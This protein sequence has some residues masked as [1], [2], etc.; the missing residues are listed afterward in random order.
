MKLTK[1]KISKIIK[2][3]NQS[4]KKFNKKR[5]L[6]PFSVKNK[7]KNNNLNKKSLKLQ[8]YK[9]TNSNK[10]KKKKKVKKK[11]GGAPGYDDGYS[12]NPYATE[13]FTPISYDDEDIDMGAAEFGG[14]Y[15]YNSDEEREAQEN[16]SRIHARAAEAE[17]EEAER[18]E[19][20][21][22]LAERQKA[23]RLKA[24]RQKAER[25]LAE[26]QLAQQQ[27]AQ[28]Q[29]TQQQLAQPMVTKKEAERQ[30]AREQAQRQQ[31]ERLRQREEQRAQAQR[32]KAER[33]RQKEEQRA[34]TL[35]QRAE[36]KEA[37]R[38]A[39]QP[40]KE[41]QKKEREAERAERQKYIEQQQRDITQQIANAERVRKKF[42]QLNAQRKQESERL[43]Q[44]RLT[45]QPE[46]RLS[47]SP[48][49]GLDPT[50]FSQPPASPTPV[51]ESSITTPISSPVTTPVSSPLQPKFISTTR[52]AF[53]LP[54]E[55]PPSRLDAHLD[56]SDRPLVLNP[57]KTGDGNNGTRKTSL[58][59]SAKSAIGQVGTRAIA[60]FRRFTQ[61]KPRAE[62]PKHIEM[63]TSKRNVPPS[64][65]PQDSLPD[66]H[67]QFQPEIAQFQ[68]EI[69]SGRLSS[70]NLSSRPS[71]ISLKS[72]LSGL[73]SPELSH[74]SSISE[75]SCGAVPDRTETPIRYDPL[76]S[77]RSFRDLVPGEGSRPDQNQ[78]LEL[79]D[80]A[81]TSPPQVTSTVPFE[82]VQPEPGRRSPPVSESLELQDTSLPRTRCGAVANLGS[83]SQPPTPPP[84]QLS[85]LDEAPSSRIIPGSIE[86][87]TIRGPAPET[88]EEP[89]SAR[90]NT[91]FLELLDIINDEVPD[92]NSE[93]LQG[94]IN[95]AFREGVDKMTDGDQLLKN[96]EKKLS[97][98]K[99]DE[100]KAR[101]QQE[102]EEKKVRKEGEKARKQQEK[103][104]KKL[105]KEWEKE[106]K[107]REKRN[108]IQNKLH[109][110]E[111]EIM[112]G[113]ETDSVK[114]LGKEKELQENLESFAIIL[115]NSILNK[116][117]NNNQN[118][119]INLEDKVSKTF[120]YKKLIKDL[121]DGKVDKEIK[122]FDYNVLNRIF[123]A[124]NI[125]KNSLTYNFLVK[126]NDI[127]PWNKQ[128]DKEDSKE[129]INISGG[130]KPIVKPP[131]TK[132]NPN[133][134]IDT[135]SYLSPEN[136]SQTDEIS[137]LLK[138]TINKDFP[139]LNLAY[140]SE[141]EYKEEK[142]ESLQIKLK[143]LGSILNKSEVDLLKII[144]NF[145]EKMLEINLDDLKE[146]S[147]K[148]NKIVNTLQKLFD[149][150]TYTYLGIKKGVD[151]QKFQDARDI[152]M[153]K[154]DKNQ[155]DGKV[156]GRERAINS[157]KLRKEE[158]EKR[159]ISLEK[160]RLENEKKEQE[161]ED[162]GSEYGIKGGGVEDSDY[163][164]IPYK[165]DIN[166]GELILINTNNNLNSNIIFG[167]FVD[168]DL[169]SGV[170]LFLDKPLAIN[171]DNIGEI[172]IKLEYTPKFNEKLMDLCKQYFKDIILRI[173]LAT[174]INNPCNPR[175]ND[176][177]INRFLSK[178]MS[179]YADTIQP[180]E[181]K[182]FKFGPDP[183]KEKIDQIILDI[184]KFIKSFYNQ[185]TD[186]NPEEKTPEQ[187]IKKLEEIKN[188]DF[189][190]QR[191][192]FEELDEKLQSKM[193]SITEA[194]DGEN[195]DIFTDYYKLCNQDVVNELR[196]KSQEDEKIKD[197]RLSDKK[198][199]YI[200][201][202]FNLNSFEELFF[203]KN[204]NEIGIYRDDR[205]DR[206][207]R[208]IFKL[209]L[210]IYEINQEPL[211]IIIEI[212]NGKKTKQ[213]EDREDQDRHEK[214]LQQIEE[215]SR[216]RK[217][218]LS[219][220]EYLQNIREIQPG[221]FLPGE[222]IYNP[223][224]SVGNSAVSSLTTLLSKNKP[225]FIPSE[226]KFEAPGTCAALSGPSCGALTS[227]DVSPKPTNFGSLA[228]GTLPLPDEDEALTNPQLNEEEFKE[229]IKNF[230]TD[231]FQNNPKIIE[232]F[233]KDHS[234]VDSV[235]I[236]ENIL[237]RLNNILDN[238][239]EEEASE[240]GEEES[241]APPEVAQEEA[242]E[243]APEA[244][245][246]VS[247][248][249]EE[250]AEVDPE[251]PAEVEAEQPAEVEEAPAVEEPP[252]V[253]E[254]PAAETPVR[255]A[256]VEGEEL[257]GGG[258]VF[259]KL[260][261]NKEL[262]IKNNNAV[263]LSNNKFKGGAKE[264]DLIVSQIYT[265]I[266]KFFEDIKAIQPNTKTDIEIIN[267]LVRIYKIFKNQEKNFN[268]LNDLIKP[269]LPEIIKYLR[270][271]SDISKFTYYHAETKSPGTSAEASV[272]APFNFNN[273]ETVFFGKS[274][275]GI[276]YNQYIKLGKSVTDQAPGNIKLTDK[277]NDLYKKDNY[278]KIFGSLLEI[279]NSR[280]EPMNEIIKILNT[281]KDKPSKVGKEE[282]PEIV[283]E[284]EESQHES[285]PPPLLEESDE[286]EEQEDQEEPEEPKVTCGVASGA[287]CGASNMS[288]LA[289]IERVE[290][291][292][293]EETA[294]INQGIENVRIKLNENLELQKAL[295][296]GN[297][298]TLSIDNKKKYD[299]IWSIPEK[300][301]RSMKGGLFGMLA[302]G[303]S[304]VGR[305][306]VAV[307]EGAVKVGTKVGEGVVKGAKVVGKGVE[308]GYKVAQDSAK[309]VGNV[310]SKGYKIA[311]DGA[312]VVGDAASKG[313]KIAEDGAKV[314]GDG[315]K[316]IYNVAK[317]GAKVVGEGLESGKKLT[318][319]VGLSVK[320]GLETGKKFTRKI[321][322]RIGEG[323]ETGKILG[324]NYILHPAEKLASKAKSGLK[325]VGNKA[326]HYIIKPGEK[327]YNFTKK[328][329]EDAG[330]M[331]TRTKKLLGETRVGK[332]AIG[333]KNLTKRAY[334][335]ARGKANKD[336]HRGK[337]SRKDKKGKG[338]LESAWENTPSVGNNWFGSR[339]PIRGPRIVR[340]GSS[341]TTNTYNINDASGLEL[342]N[343]NKKVPGAVVPGAAVPGEAVPGARVPGAT[344]V[345][346][347]ESGV[348]GFFNRTKRATG[349]MVNKTR[350]AAA[351]KIGE[352]RQILI[353]REAKKL[354]EKGEMISTE[355]L[356]EF[357]K[358]NKGLIESKVSEDKQRELIAISEM[359]MDMTGEDK[360]KAMNLIN[361]YTRETED[362]E[363]K[364]YED[365]LLLLLW[366]EK[367]MGVRLSEE[368][369]KE[370][371]EGIKNILE[372]PYKMMGE[373]ERKEA[374]GSR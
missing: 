180:T 373:I 312:E 284:P 148:K 25:Q 313:Y 19:E 81:A 237:S 317:D 334:K 82:S 70:L 364:V 102:K 144:E 12:Y 363:I 50:Y 115:N 83:T 120:N 30:L 13:D 185:I 206:D 308:V 131:I 324:K 55:L 249:G 299:K 123:L 16:I 119:L 61:R 44:E 113:L 251:Q 283:S 3:K 35:R 161:L 229:K 254:A 188:N 196:K 342:T 227:S 171:F 370:R 132:I 153:D 366:S 307:G 170:I 176:S 199:I 4:Y 272:S 204:P 211:N 87:N 247:E 65:G 168:L 134:P 160:Q 11:K 351:R 356:G 336:D 158:E 51:A 298:E 135:G 21:R 280:K 192:N 216:Q 343:N 270:E 242:P 45:E 186:F 46:T 278:K 88:E 78:L 165:D 127:K 52:P 245:P 95:E 289:A 59:K 347:E 235:G 195:L 139:V 56:A 269:K 98:L 129:K 107:V 231:I 257:R 241:E 250:A 42:K 24:E 130:G 285:A 67:P 329:A 282:T 43:Q 368:K 175:N 112:E 108:K 217:L 328:K 99:K 159:K 23:E 226:D 48:E 277:L 290:H 265:F 76:R 2:T 128:I 238:N 244:A 10:N 321:G 190:K 40:E 105:R 53:P 5:N 183:E 232:N 75:A 80:L 344:S 222:V 147:D 69:D 79:Q 152:L 151:K 345:A 296:E 33:Q 177:K 155:E 90:A 77:S 202:P 137:Q 337:K 200:F 63:K 215:R 350:K 22:Q 92:M 140:F 110:F 62:K 300:I 37:E 73:S 274:N 122:N 146:E 28:Q 103:E 357:L 294:K 207:Y 263:I 97:E 205:P 138:I 271:K 162:L 174:P 94:L 239:E 219:A 164:K 253:E 36:A 340:E 121:D 41:R 32:E 214:R 304:T 96:A 320:E 197:F 145:L 72:Q 338:W 198:E 341:K 220:R 261:A 64:F 266:S 234:P 223:T 31:A 365:Y 358:N 288:E 325:Y 184:K 264:T 371:L 154:S 332:A 246:E 335:W 248:E 305:A 218:Q 14:P 38:Q 369:T 193:V 181:E 309:V 323:I 302:R 187:I 295:K 39:R 179:G 221:T 273:L 352:T 240:V 71:N 268:E 93:R 225:N 267:E 306:A 228:C 201:F 301:K 286:Q 339:S 255:E 293:E 163:Q 292:S 372:A 262:Q 315:Y 178:T 203:G 330:E 9:K 252:A 310:A 297:R 58:L 349:N 362:P 104:D 149:I 322:N 360:M 47:S 276:I 8:K 100:E 182:V 233:Q 7:Y 136:Q 258:T 34:E 287:A 20:Q 26:R 194:I 279:Y 17:R 172:S 66:T 331:Y 85:S 275:T 346:E 124:G 354:A 49:E 111:E 118:F 359:T 86:M 169:F 355:K 166:P 60:P 210:R 212:L 367:A 374:E 114:I 101:K 15:N 27:L 143:F 6:S 74:R 348:R 141:M 311:K 208:E 256:R 326:D 243:R 260:H 117:D 167:N 68:P 259:E 314:V 156:S 291:E 1:N 57:S 353:T 106:F 230:L 142:D 125:P 303:A 327:A 150:N 84:R 89:E 224:G 126:N 109:A 54:I 333:A 316:K 157:E 209:L 133:L 91:L 318:R 116:L 191:K 281:K 173:G 319:R 361:S 213:D 18:Q 189:E 236:M 29:L